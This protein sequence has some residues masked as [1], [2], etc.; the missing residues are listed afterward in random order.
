MSNHFIGT[1]ISIAEG[2]IHDEITSG[3]IGVNFTLPNGKIT[4]AFITFNLDDFKKVD[5]SNT[6][7]FTNEV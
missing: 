6:G 4:E 3:K 2:L 5:D 1:M 7:E